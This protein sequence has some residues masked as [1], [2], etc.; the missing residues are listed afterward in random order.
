MTRLRF[1]GSS[2]S[3]GVPRWWCHCAVCEEARSTRL[4]ARTRPSALIEGCERILIDASPELRLQMT[5]EEIDQVDAVL[6]THAH[7]DHILGLGDLVDRARWTK[8]LCP[9]YLPEEVVPQARERFAYLE[10]G[11]FY[12]KYA[13]LK[14]LESAPGTF[15]GY[16]VRPVKVPHG[17]NGWSYALRFG[18]EGGS[19]G[20]M[21]DCI[22][23]Q[24]LEPWR[25]LDLLVLGTSFYHEAAPLEGRSVYDVLEGLELIAEL[26]PQQTVLTHLGHGVD[27]RTPLPE[28]VVFAQ[29][30]LVV[31]LP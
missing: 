25:D 30:G 9:V 8:L 22:G 2:D 12:P 5:R 14:S 13:P 6:V 19:W 21:S 7:N 11:D 15:A 3:Q 27:I 10:R 23:L 20:Y 18:G 29:D 24:D 28:G 26:K 4:N 16:Q 17:W 31:E 1:L